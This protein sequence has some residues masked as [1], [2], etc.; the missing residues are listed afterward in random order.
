MAKSKRPKVQDVAKFGGVDDLGTVR[1]ENVTPF[2]SE[3]SQTEYSRDEATSYDVKSI[4]VQSQTKLESD[5]GYGKA[6]VLRMFEFKMNPLTF[7]TVRPSHQ[8]LFNAHYKGIETTLWKDGLKV[9]PDINPRI[10]INQEEQTY[11][12][13]VGATPAKGQLLK[14]EPKTLSE[15]V[16]G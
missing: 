13:F 8:D 6:V 2:F 4:E 1:D 14:E 7:S 3:L 15:I 9:L 10:L 16:H 5:E 12:I 11:R